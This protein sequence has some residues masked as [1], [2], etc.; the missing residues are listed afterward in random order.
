MRRKKEADSFFTKVAT[1]E[2]GFGKTTFAGCH[3][4]NRYPSGCMLKVRIQGFTYRNINQTNLS[5]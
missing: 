5:S 2:E 4:R 1:T 3:H